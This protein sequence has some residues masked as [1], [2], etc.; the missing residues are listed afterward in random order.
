MRGINSNTD[1]LL[2]NFL[3][4]TELKH[5]LRKTHSFFEEYDR[6]IDDQLID[7]S[8][9]ESESSTLLIDD[10]PLHASHSVRLG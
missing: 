8:A 5:L 4:L 9:D 1:V 7:P 6:H 10:R 3:D 2:K